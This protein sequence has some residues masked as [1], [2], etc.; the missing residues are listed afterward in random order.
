MNRDGETHGVDVSSKVDFEDGEPLQYSSGSHVSGTSKVVR[1]VIKCS[2]GYIENEK[3]ASYL[4]LGFV[5]LVI[6]FSV[7]FA[8]GSF[9]DSSEV[10]PYEETYQR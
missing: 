5:L 3:Q 2:G 4:V 9:P 1:W 6:I 7:V 8:V 10:V